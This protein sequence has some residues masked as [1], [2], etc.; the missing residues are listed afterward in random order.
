MRDLLTSLRAKFLRLGRAAAALRLR[1]SSRRRNGFTLIE[2]LAAFA[3][4]ILVMSNLLQGVSNGAR[5][6]AYSDFLTSARRD[7]QSQLEALGIAAPLLPGETAGTYDDGL[8]WSLSVTPY[9][10][11]GGGAGGGQRVLGYA[12]RLVVRRPAG[13]DRAQSMTFATVKLAQE[14]ERKQ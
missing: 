4:L 3:I 1:S 9:R 12:T 8:Q 13:A 14:Q 2:T 7:A 11:A 6:E 10:S 5:N